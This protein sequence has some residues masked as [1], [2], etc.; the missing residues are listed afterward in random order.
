MKESTDDGITVRISYEPRPARV[1]TNEEQVAEI[2]NYYKEVEEQGANIEQIEANK[3]TMSKVTQI[4]NHP[5]RIRKVA[6]DIVEHYEKVVSEKP[7]IVQKPWLFV[8]TV[9]MLLTFT[10]L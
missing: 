8:R 2:D 9:N 4:L 5:D 6:D 7:E 1:I 10:K 3:R